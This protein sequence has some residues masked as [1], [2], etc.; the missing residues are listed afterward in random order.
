M[1]SARFEELLNSRAVLLNAVDFTTAKRAF[2]AKAA[3]D[4]ARFPSSTIS[5]AVR[6]AVSDCMS[7]TA[8]SAPAS[9]NARA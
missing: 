1:K 8:T 6:A 5:E 2:E 9:A 3:I 7:T 4:R